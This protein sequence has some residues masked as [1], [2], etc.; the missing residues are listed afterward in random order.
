MDTTHTTRAART[1]RQNDG[2][3]NVRTFGSLGLHLAPRTTPTTKVKKDEPIAPA[4]TDDS[5]STD[6]GS[7]TTKIQQDEPTPAKVISD[8]PLPTS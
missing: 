3:I 1:Q 6:T 2:I 5:T 7:K 4:P 8:E